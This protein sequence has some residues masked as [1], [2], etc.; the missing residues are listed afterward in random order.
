LK[1]PYPSNQ[2]GVIDKFI[3]EGL[4]V[5]NNGYAITKLGALLFSKQLK[6]FESVETQIGQGYRLQRQKQS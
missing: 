4:V 6:D 2:Q 5:K 1:L 3:D